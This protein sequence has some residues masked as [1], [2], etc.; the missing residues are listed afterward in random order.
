M[1]ALAPASERPVFMM[2]SGLS[3]TKALRAAAWK[4]TVETDAKSGRDSLWKVDESG[5]IGTT[6]SNP[7]LRCDTSQLLLQARSFAAHF[8]ESGTDDGCRLH[9]FGSA[10]CQGFG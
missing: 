6:E 8:G 2:M 10:F 5:T 3:K 9:A 1:L 4:A 7:I